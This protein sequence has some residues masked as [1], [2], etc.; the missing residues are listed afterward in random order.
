MQPIRIVI[1][2]EFWDSYVYRGRLYLWRLDGS[3]SVVDW[4][5]AVASLASRSRGLALTCAFVR[6]DLLYQRTAWE[7]IFGDPDVQ[8]L[9][10]QK[11][12]N[13][14][15]SELILDA[16][17]VAKFQ[18]GHQDTPFGVLHDDLAMYGSTLFAL[19]E[20][21]TFAAGA[22]KNRKN[23]HKIE[24]QATRLWDGGGMCIRA[25]SAALAIAAGDDGLFELPVRDGIAAKPESVCD[26]HATFV[27]WA[28]SSMYASSRVSGGYL[29]GY[30]WEEPKAEAGTPRTRKFAGI[31][32]ESDVFGNGGD[33]LS[34]GAQEKVYRMVGRCVSAVRF[35]QSRLL[36]S[37]TRTDAFEEI[38]TMDV[39]EESSL[40]SGGVS[41]FGTVLEYDHG[42][43]VIDSSERHKFIAGPLLRWRVFPR[44]D[45][46]QNHLHV[47]FPDRLEIF[48]FNGDYF[49][50]QEGKKMGIRF[51]ALPARYGRFGPAIRFEEFG[52]GA[53]ARAKDSRSR[54]DVG[55]DDI[56][57]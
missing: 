5:A 43:L 14:A 10:K 45:R 21:G 23:V 52:G 46:Y 37:A 49:V 38:G 39:S 47:V 55:D 54:Y 25:G 56:P 41:F 26:R 24:R 53:V 50:D 4:D 36:D 13:L 16:R 32:D 40:V 9:L 20:R 33:G 44:A 19:T 34:W 29:A 18:M 51:R 31:F 30:G 28:F 22:H 2:G 1:P 27:E 11:F 57:F 48:S 6:G 35:T 15:R 17:A 42:L 8:G 3:V 7:L 12:R